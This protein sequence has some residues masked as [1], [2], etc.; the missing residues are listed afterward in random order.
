MMERNIFGAYFSGGL[1]KFIDPEI[2]LMLIFLVSSK[3][4]YIHKYIWYLLFL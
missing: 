2:Y 4:L 3:Y 1:Q